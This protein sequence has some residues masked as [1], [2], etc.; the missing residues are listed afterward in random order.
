MKKLF[1][2]LDDERNIPDNYKRYFKDWGINFITLRTYQSV[3]DY[4][5]K[6]R[7]ID[8]KIYLSFDH[9]LGLNKTGYDVAKFIVENQI[10]INGFAVHSMNPVGAKNII[11]LLTHYG[12]HQMKAL[13]EII[14]D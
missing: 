1:I 6:Y 14:Q 13:N 10:S 12:Y 4:L 9:D 11:E 7:P 3:I 5:T 8:A 2:Y